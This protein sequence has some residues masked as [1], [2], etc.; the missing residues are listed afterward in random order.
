MPKVK[1]LRA[2]NRSQQY[3]KRYSRSVGGSALLGL[4]LGIMGVFMMLPLV[5]AVVSAF[6]PL[7]EFFIF[8]PRFYVVNP[9]LENFSSLW[10]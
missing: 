1:R 3:A 8:P 10:T 9:T 2:G 5:Y 4:L 6:K 7:E